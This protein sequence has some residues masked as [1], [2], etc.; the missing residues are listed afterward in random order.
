MFQ[1]DTTHILNTLSTLSVDTDN[2]KAIVQKSAGFKVTGIAVDTPY[3]DSLI[4][5]DTVSPV[6]LPFQGFEG[7]LL[8]STPENQV[9]VFLCLLGLFFLLIFFFWRYPFFFK[10]TFRSYIKSSENNIFSKDDLNNTIPFFMVLYSIGVV[11][12]FA[13]VFL[14][15]PTE[16]FLPIT[17]FKFFLATTVFFLFKWLIIKLIGYVFLD[18]VTFNMAKQIYFSLFF[19]F[20]TILFPLLTIQIYL[21]EKSTLT[22]IAALFL[23]IVAF[24]AFIIKFFQIFSTKF[25]AFF[26]IFLYLCTLEILPLILLVKTYQRII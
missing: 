13:A 11:S 14:H 10:N 18:K 16:P 22:S 24:I 5:F 17:C 4:H 12:M 7:I 15:Y 25:A 23:F 8:P 26:Y 19:L 1:P 6:Q 9:W 21:P 3:P 20:A 2:V